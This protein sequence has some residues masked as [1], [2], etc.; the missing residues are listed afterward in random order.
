MRF[1]R[2]FG[3]RREVQFSSIFAE[4]R[5]TISPRN[6][7]IHCPNRFIKDEKDDAIPPCPF[8]IDWLMTIVP[9]SRED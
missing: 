1:H 3:I 6:L 5:K 9:V 7:L 8:S 4:K 2:L